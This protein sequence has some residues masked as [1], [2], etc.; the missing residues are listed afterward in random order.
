MDNSNNKNKSERWSKIVAAFM[1]L[2]IVEA[3][4]YGGYLIRYLD[5]AE[6]LQVALGTPVICLVMMLVVYFCSTRSGEGG[7]GHESGAMRMNKEINDAGFPSV[8]IKGDVRNAASAWTFSLL[9]LALIVWR[10]EVD[11]NF[12]RKSL[13]VVCFGFLAIACFLI[14]WCVSR[15]KFIITFQS[16]RFI[17]SRSIGLGAAKQMEFSYDECRAFRA[18]R[19]QGSSN[20]VLSIDGCNGEH[21][22]IKCN[23]K[24]ADEICAYANKQIEQHRAKNQE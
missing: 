1:V 7:F 9:L 24:L 13:C 4:I 2:I 20:P 19:V 17:I 5:R 23:R 21:V 6:F 3:I 16:D 12:V 18:D 15:M 14:G 22:T 10:W 8:S 11:G